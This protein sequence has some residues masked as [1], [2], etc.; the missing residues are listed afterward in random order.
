MASVVAALGP[1]VSGQSLTASPPQFEVASIKL[2][3][4]PGPANNWSVSGQRF[5]GAMSQVYELIHLAWGDF[6]L[7]IDNAPAWTSG[8]RYDVIANAGVDITPSSPIVSQMMRAL[9]VDRFK[10][11]A[12]LETREAQSYK[13]RLARTDP[14]LGPRLE[15]PMA[16]CPVAT[17][18]A[19]QGPCGP[20]QQ[21]DAL[22]FG[23]TKVS[24]LTWILGLIVGARVEDE[25]GLT[26]SYRV[27]LKFTPPPRLAPLDANNPIPAV[28]AEAPSIFEAV[29]EQL[30]LKLVPF[31]GTIDVLVIDRI[32]RPT[33]D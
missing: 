16:D 33:P 3:Q 14:K 29:E 15:P 1:D 10:L 28:S 23:N 21:P 27:N 31:K 24:N 25:T 2:N 13:L 6:Q 17:G 8:E 19:A 26:D 32:E 7:R 22:I 9:L 30:G 4:E 5:N 18:T 20:G 11:A 12:H